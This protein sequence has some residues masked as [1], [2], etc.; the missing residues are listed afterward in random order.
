ME[1]RPIVPLHNQ[2]IGLLQSWGGHNE[3]N[4]YNDDDFFDTRLYL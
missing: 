4:G 1:S 3:S 2:L